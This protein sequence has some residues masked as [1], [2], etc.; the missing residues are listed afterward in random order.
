MA[1]ETDPPVPVGGTGP[2]I[3]SYGGGRCAVCSIK[4]RTGYLMCP[5][6]WDQVP[7]DIKAAVYDCLR[8]WNVNQISLE[9]LRT[10]QQ[11][12]VEAVTGTRRENTLEG[13]EQV[14]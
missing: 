7:S 4:T 14:V 11:A 12:A 8:L 9:D 10:A 13:G 3:V 2:T 1:T 6:H 5:R